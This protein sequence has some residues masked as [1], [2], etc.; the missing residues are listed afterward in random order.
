MDRQLADCH[1]CKKTFARDRLGPLDTGTRQPIF[2]DER[3][4]TFGGARIGAEPQWR[5]MTIPK[6]LRACA[7]C[8]GDVPPIHTVVGRQPLWAPKDL[9][10]RLVKRA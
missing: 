5:R 1:V 4:K 8:G 2:W 3:H 6:I 7:G 10:P 9:R